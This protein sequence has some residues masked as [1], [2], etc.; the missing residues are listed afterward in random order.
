M[1]ITVVEPS[2]T[3]V[4]TDT[5]RAAVVRAFGEPL[6]V[7]QVPVLGLEPG[8]VRVRVEASGL[9]IP[10]SMPPMATGP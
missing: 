2:L 8:Q 4:P 5:Y 7:E 10:T 6:T 1:S 9:S 3:E